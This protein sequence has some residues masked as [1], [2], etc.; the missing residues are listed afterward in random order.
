VTAPA[1]VSAAE[2]APRMARTTVGAARPESADRVVLDE[3]LIA[4][5]A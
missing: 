2:F 1:V 3:M 5:L 4:L